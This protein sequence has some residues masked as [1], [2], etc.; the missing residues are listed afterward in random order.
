M[1]STRV[2]LLAGIQIAINA[3][4]ERSNGVKIKAAGSQTLTP[5]R[6]L[7]RKRVSQMAPPIPIA[8]PIK[9]RG[10]TLPQDHVADVGGCAPSAMRTPS[11]CVRC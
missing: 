11:S 7:A 2:A 9:A 6:K 4:A 1:G 3:T 10:H 5:N 8:T